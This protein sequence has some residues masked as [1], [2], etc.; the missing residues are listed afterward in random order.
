M[1]YQ[2]NSNNIELTVHTSCYC[3]LGLL[4]VTLLA[5][6]GVEFGCHFVQLGTMQGLSSHP[7]FIPCIPKS[8][9]IFL[10]SLQSEV[11]VA[12]GYLNLVERLQEERAVVEQTF[13]SEKN[14]SSINDLDYFEKLTNPGLN[15]YF[16]NEA[17]NNLFER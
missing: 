11:S 17:T 13:L 2:V 6:M 9:Y 14:Y 10:F 5:G 4:C 15:G 8:K 1:F 7:N 3:V 16:C 12:L